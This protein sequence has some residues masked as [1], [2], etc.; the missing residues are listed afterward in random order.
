MSGSGTVTQRHHELIVEGS[1]GRRVSTRVA[2][3]VA[4]AS[5]VN[6]D[7]GGGGESNEGDVC[8]CQQWGGEERAISIASATKGA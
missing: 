6:V 4:V 1:N 8:E 5:G 7:N 2:K 3:E